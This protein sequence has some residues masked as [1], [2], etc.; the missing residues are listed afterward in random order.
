MWIF[1]LFCYC[2]GNLVGKTLFAMPM[3]SL[4]PIWAKRVNDKGQGSIFVFCC[5]AISSPAFFDE[6]LIAFVGMMEIIG[7]RFRGRSCRRCLQMSD[8]IDWNL[9][10]VRIVER[11][12]ERFGLILGRNY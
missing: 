1:A 6:L 11:I 12:V 8:G 10:G 2:R 9:R 7:A 4:T 5:S 3:M